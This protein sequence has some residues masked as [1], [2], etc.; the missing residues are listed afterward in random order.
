M[1]KNIKMYI[2]RKI[3]FYILTSTL[4]DYRYPRKNQVLNKLMIYNECK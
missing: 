3:S 1:K 2:F 4:I